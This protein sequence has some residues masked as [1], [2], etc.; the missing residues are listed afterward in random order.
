MDRKLR[1]EALESRC[2]LSG[3]PVLLEAACDTTANT[4]TLRFSEVMEAAPAVDPGN[5]RIEMVGGDTLSITSATLNTD[6]TAV[7][8]NLAEQVSELYVYRILVRADRLKSDDGIA[9]GNTA[10][11]VA[12]GNTANLTIIPGMRDGEFAPPFTYEWWDQ[13]LMTSYTAT[14]DFNNDGW[15]DAATIS[16]LDGEVSVF[17][18]NGSAYSFSAPMQSSIGH[19][20]GPT[21]TGDFNGDGNLDMVVLCEDAHS[22]IVVPRY[23]LLLGNGDGTFERVSTVAVAGKP[24]DVPAGD[25]HGDG[26]LDLVF[27]GTSR[28][29]FVAGN[30]S[31]SFAPPVVSNDEGPAN[32]C[33]ADFNGD[34][35]LDLLRGVVRLG[36][37]DGTFQPANGYAVEAIPLVA[38]FNNDGRIDFASLIR[39]WGVSNTISVHLNDGNGFQD[40]LLFDIPLSVVTTAVTGDFNGDGIT[41]VAVG[42]RLDGAADANGRLLTFIG[43]GDGTFVLANARDTCHLLDMV[44]GQ[45][46]PFKQVGYIGQ[47][48]DVAGL[49]VFGVQ[50]LAN[51]STTTQESTES[52]PTQAE[53]TQ[54][55]IMAALA[56]LE[57]ETEIS[58]SPVTSNSDIYPDATAK[59][60]LV[61]SPL[62][63]NTRHGSGSAAS[64]P[65]PSPQAQASANEQEPPAVYEDPEQVS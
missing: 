63:E 31:G 12:I 47:P 62:L 57:R 44:S 6:G 26:N 2:Y 59:S 3:A 33:A 58:V 36:N 7:T 1:F 4:L 23:S 18:G 43:Q 5:Y 55:A 27:A 8:L 40:L 50:C 56:D 10:D 24:R 48:S 20:G 34:G 32:V 25:V 22:W 64:T 29:S 37:G 39:T 38:D 46:A 11:L 53:L 21:V 54:A 49:S 61:S 15:L 14:G 51:A 42:G 45:F 17:L 41:D 13:Y 28:L 9:I 52:E 35:I 65:E 60:N 30:G 19:G 16:E